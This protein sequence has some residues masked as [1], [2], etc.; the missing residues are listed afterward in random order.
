MPR[1]GPRAGAG[2][3][4]TLSDVPSVHF[5]FRLPREMRDEV[6]QRGGGAWLREIITRELGSLDDRVTPEETEIDMDG[7]FCTLVYTRDTRPTGCKPLPAGPWKSE[8]EAW[9]AFARFNTY[10][11]AKFG[12]GAEAFTN[13]DRPR[14][15][16][17]SR[18]ACQSATWKQALEQERE[19]TASRE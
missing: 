8:E 16:R 13:G 11:N 10:T 6:Q 4:A 17:G 1:G 15:F 19:L 7:N 12:C 5:A 9:E 18:R 3:K 14:I 2:R